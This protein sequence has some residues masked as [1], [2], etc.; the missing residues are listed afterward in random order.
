MGF[1][2]E[3][4]AGGRCA[5][6][7]LRAGA[8]CGKLSCGLRWTITRICGDS[9]GFRVM[10]SPG[11]PMTQICGDTCG[12]RVMKHCGHDTDLGGFP[13]NPCHGPVPGN[14]MTQI[15]GL[16]LQSR[17][18]VLSVFFPGHTHKT[19]SS[20]FAPGIGG[21]DGGLSSEGLG[22]GRSALS[23]CEGERLA[24]RANSESHRKSCI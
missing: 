3:D 7:L 4:V 19:F 2:A 14:P 9:F 17:V 12:F 1:T 22:H 16:F 6:G 15:L 20:I 8:S 13:P 5:M 10:G 11:F 24:F 23:A 21:Q 18:M